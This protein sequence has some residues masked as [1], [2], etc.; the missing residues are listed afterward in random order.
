MPLLIPKTQCAICSVHAL[1]TGDINRVW[2]EERRPRDKMQ[3]NT[4]EHHIICY[5]QSHSRWLVPGCHTPPPSWP[6]ARWY[7]PAAPG[8][9]L[10]AFSAAQT[11]PAPSESRQYAAISEEEHPG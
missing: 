7:P 10:C 3:I 1:N 11:S 8:C 9:C 4:T 5:G 2:R 6:V